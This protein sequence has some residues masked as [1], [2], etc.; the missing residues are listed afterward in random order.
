[1]LC[2]RWFTLLFLLTFSLSAQAKNWLEITDEVAAIFPQATRMLAS[3]DDLPALEIYQLD[4]KIGY[5]FDTDDLT[6]FPGFSGDTVNLRMGLSMDGT[7]AG[8]VLDKH[9][10]PIFLHGLGEAPLID[11]INQYQQLA[12]KNRVI[13]GSRQARLDND[14]ILYVD[15]VTKATVSVMVV[16]DTMLSAVRQVA[17]ARLD[18]FSAGSGATLNLDKF[19][20]VPAENLQTEGLISRWVL[21]HQAVAESLALEIDPIYAL[22]DQAEQFMTMTVAMLNAPSIGRNIL[23]DKEFSRLQQKLKPGDIALL[24]GSD[25]GYQVVGEDFVPGTSPTRLSLS[26]QGIDLALR[27]SD[28][29]HF[30]PPSFREGIAPF[31]M[32][33]VFIFSARGGFDPALPLDLT[34]NLHIAKNHL[35]SETYTLTHSFSLPESVIIQRSLLPQEET[36]LPLWQRIWQQRY[37]ELVILSLYLLMLV[38]AFTFQRRLAG[39]FGAKLPEIRLL[40]MTFVI[41]FIGFYAQGQLSVVNIYT[42]L[43]SIW[44]GF[45]VT[46]FLLDPM[47]FVLWSFVFVSLFL[48][49][50]GMFCGWLCPFGAMQEL[51]ARAA[52][53]L[54]L[55][56]WQVSEKADKLLLGS[57]YLI[58]ITLTAIAFFDLSLAETLSEVEPFKTAVTLVFDRSWPFVIYAVLLLLLS[59]R[60]H[61]AYCRYLC[62]LGA[63]LAVLGRFRL[64]SWLDRRKECGTS[65]RLCEKRCGI[66]AINRDGSIDYNECI[67]CFDCLAIIKSDNR[68]VADKYARRQRRPSARQKSL[69]ITTVS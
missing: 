22:N 4:Q 19:Q 11:F 14:D 60:V 58:L 32:V 45:E 62:P 3:D 64:F 25:E 36:P 55:R 7:I 31:E 49:G 27:D 15:G 29:Y 17:R 42:L 43:L 6:D 54:R 51:V 26:Q 37:I 53:R 8:I 28:F 57:K 23:G 44:N 66:G 61:K 21:S 56:Q 10:E 67:Q 68:C 13:V 48:W 24:V 50:R 35:E 12:I 47:L 5:V 63:G 2:R 38:V 18:G 30:Y 34:L 52:E 20:P 46:V 41:L 1:M 16:H 9:H 39:S 40:A 69:D 65:C 59:S 33:K